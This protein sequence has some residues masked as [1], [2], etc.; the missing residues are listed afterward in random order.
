MYPHGISLGRPAAVFRCTLLSLLV[1]AISCSSHP[2]SF[3]DVIYLPIRVGE[4]LGGGHKGGVVSKRSFSEN[5]LCET[6]L[7]LLYWAAHSKG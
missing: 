1:S 7:F 2:W 4:P 5:L 3:H 6:T